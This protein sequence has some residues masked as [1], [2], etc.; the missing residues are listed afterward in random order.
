MSGARAKKPPFPWGAYIAG[1]LTVGVL[2]W[3][4]IGTGASLPVLIEGLPNVG[5]FFT[6]MVPA[7]KNPAEEISK[8]LTE[9]GPR[10][11]ETLRIAVAATFF[12]AVL[13][14]PFPLLGSRNLATK[15][16][17]FFGRAVLNF[18]R[19]IPDLVLALLIAIAF[20]FNA[21]SGFLALLLFSF[22]V[23]AKLLCDT[24][25]TL[26][27]G[28]LEAIAATGGTRVEQAVYGI[29]PQVA[30]DFA[31]YTL[32]AFEINIRSAS[33]LGLVG[34]G[35]VG[36]LLNKYVNFMNYG[37]LGMIIGIIFVLVVAI[38][39]FSTWLRSKLV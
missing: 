5:K 2:I 37:K 4:A 25:E 8:V 22:G 28:P 17:Y 15:V 23:V 14:L 13:A 18:V 27:P 39:G 10:L 19:S 31:A 34:A 9:I 30:P 24:V 7:G 6:E 16:V 3:S 20:G 12:G 36:V 11:L 35:G 32:Y 38:D 33:I 21:F 1:V 29:F 26:D